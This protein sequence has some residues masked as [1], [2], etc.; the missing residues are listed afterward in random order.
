[1]I[2][3]IGFRIAM[4][5]A[6]TLTGW[7][8]TRE[9]EEREGAGR[10]SVTDALGRGSTAGFAR[11][12]EPR[13]FVFPDDH[14]AHPAFRSEW[15]YFTGNVLTDTGR[16]FGYHLTFFRTALEPGVEPSSS[17][18]W[19][20]SQVWMAHFAVADVAGGQVYAHE[21]FSRGALGLAGVVASP[22]RV[23]VEDWNA[24]AVAADELL[25]LR[26]VAADGQIGIDLTLQPGKPLVL[27]GDAGLSRKS[28][29]AGNASYY[30]SFTRLPVSGRITV[31]GA[32]HAVRGLGWIDREW[33]TSALADDQTGWDWFSVQ[34]D[35]G[36]ELMWYR[37]RRR[38][39]TVDPASA[40]TLIDERGSVTRLSPEQVRLEP[41]EEWTSPRS[42]ASYPVAW[43]LEVPGADLDLRIVA[44]LRDQE[45]D[46]SVRYWE[47]AIDVGGSASG[48]GYLEMTGY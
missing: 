46:L 15:W 17:S 31:D 9:L 24:A 1:M 36:R 30:Y 19:R 45:L 37:L 18:A 5:A 23:H 39:G 48:S 2:E 28:A 26:I 16:A 44:R 41:M 22:F 11:A 32:E 38:D 21:R 33:S 29:V 4:A 13:P 6:I 40:G 27:Q 47:G 7:G 10:I 43:R 25:P 20:T 12:L 3:R 35:D 34:L 14:G 8:C 42:G